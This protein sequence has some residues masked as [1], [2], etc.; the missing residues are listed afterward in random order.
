MESCHP[1]S[2]HVELDMSVAC[3]RFSATSLS[4]SWTCSCSARRKTWA[5]GWQRSL[6]AL[7]WIVVRN[8]QRA[9]CRA[10]L[11]A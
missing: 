6:S 2:L 9:V 5:T 11:Q 10:K 8:Q 4:E 1:L 3:I 7:L